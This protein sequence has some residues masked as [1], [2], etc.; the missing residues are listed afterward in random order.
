MLRMKRNGL[1]RV[2]LGFQCIQD[3]GH[4]FQLDKTHL[5]SRN[6]RHLRYANTLSSF[7]KEKDWLNRH[8]PQSTS[9]GCRV[10]EVT[11]RHVDFYGSL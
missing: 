3:G 8:L 10:N 2:S 6:S 11:L 9:A 4:G 7:Q 1:R 5:L